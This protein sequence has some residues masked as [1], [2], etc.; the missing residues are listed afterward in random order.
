M[1]PGEEKIYF[2]KEWEAMSRAFG[3]FLKT[4]SQDD[5]H[6]FRVQ[7][8]KI[9]A[10]LTLLGSNHPHL[11]L[12][13]H[14]KPVRGLFKAAGIIR[15]A[16]I[17]LEL[18]RKYNIQNEAFINGQL[19]VI[20]NAGFDLILSG[21][22]YEEAMQKARKTLKDLL[23][24]LTD[25]HFNLFY[26]ARL[27]DLITLLTPLRFNTRLHQARTLMKQLMYNYKLAHPATG[28]NKDYVNQTQGLIG[29][30][31]DNELALQLLTDLNMSREPAFKSLKKANTALKKQIRTILANVYNDMTIMVDVPLLQVS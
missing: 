7:V 4:H 14:F 23:P 1:K 20:E 28:F 25:A 11:K 10:L 8:K 6:D 22:H 27:H 13:K 19:Q 30:W 3:S 16:H 24:A 9:N 26:E 29:D 12:R 31:H 2:E 18:S 15:N 17:N 21:K 5:L